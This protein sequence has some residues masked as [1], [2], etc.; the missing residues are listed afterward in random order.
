MKKAHLH[1]DTTVTLH[2]VPIRSSHVLVKVVVAGCN[3][4]DRKMSARLLKTIS[5]CPNSGND[6]AGIT[7]TVPSEVYD[8]HVG[9][10]VAPLHG[11][12]ALVHD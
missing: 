1:A 11:L 2:D 5:D 4:G 7:Q 3:L 10:G 9:D 12:G 6:V 8:F